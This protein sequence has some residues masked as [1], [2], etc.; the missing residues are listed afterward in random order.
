MNSC[1]SWFQKVSELSQSHGF[2]VILIVSALFPA[3]KAAQNI[4]I[5]CKSVA[6]TFK[7]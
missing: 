6:E 1:T 3:Q 4:M 7:I 5:Y 2:L